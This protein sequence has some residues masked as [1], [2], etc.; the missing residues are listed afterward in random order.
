MPRKDP[1]EQNYRKE[2][3]RGIFVLGL[4]AVLVT[5]RIQ[6]AK[7]MVTIGQTTFDA[8]PLLDITVL[9][10]SF[11]AFFM[12]L[13]LSEDIFGETMASSFRQTAKTF[14]TFYFI[15][16]AFLALIFGFYAY[17]TR[18]PYAL[19]LLGILG[20]YVVWEKLKEFKKKMASISIKT[21]LKALIMPGSI[22]TLFF[23]FMLI[24][25]GTDENWVLPSFLVGAAATV[26]FLALTQRRKHKTE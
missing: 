9:L 8:I 20:A 10:W 15:M 1:T 18:L 3:I 2:E 19:G 23:S 14:L 17:P 5:V 22:L 4:L 24:L 16:M 13:G 6:N 26:V 11:Y 12:V 21:E 7:I 25:F